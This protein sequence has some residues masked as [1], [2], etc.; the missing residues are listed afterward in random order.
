[1]TEPGCLLN[2]HGPE[3]GTVL[4]GSNKANEG[5]DIHVHTWKDIQQVCLTLKSNSL[6]DT[7]HQNTSSQTVS[8]QYP[9]VS[10]D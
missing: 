10:H 1:M 8:S 3:S 5:R 6:S 7:H 2:L 9:F 4:S